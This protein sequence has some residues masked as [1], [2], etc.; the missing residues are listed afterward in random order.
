MGL[1]RAAE[2]AAHFNGGIGREGVVH[3]CTDLISII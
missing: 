2:A 1:G 3:V